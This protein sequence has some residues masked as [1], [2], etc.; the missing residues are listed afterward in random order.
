MG[1]R[2]VYIGHRRPLGS[3]CSPAHPSCPLP[4]TS[5]SGWDLATQPPGQASSWDLPKQA[6]A[7]SGGWGNGCGEW[8]PCHTP[9]SG[10][11]SMGPSARG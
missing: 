7:W 2:G 5:N 10:I 3:C 4:R 8:L 11:L 9:S 1:T 6:G